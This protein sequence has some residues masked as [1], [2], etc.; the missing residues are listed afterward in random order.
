[1]YFYQGNEL[2]IEGQ[3]INNYSSIE[4]LADAE[5]TVQSG[6]EETGILILQGKPINETVI[7][8]GPFVMNSKE[9]IHQA[10]E[11]YHKTQFGGWPWPKYDVVHP[12]NKGRF[13]RYANG[14]EEIKNS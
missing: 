11:D 3:K 14:K 12:K 2:I 6:N 4:L 8:Y 10:F 13:A 9:E 7:Q 5:V 1:M